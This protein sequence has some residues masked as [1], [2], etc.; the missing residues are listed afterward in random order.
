[1]P[2]G[3]VRMQGFTERTD[4]EA[5]LEKKPVVTITLKDVPAGAQVMLDGKAAMPPYEWTFYPS[6]QP[7]S[8]RIEADG[9]EDCEGVFIPDKTRS[10][11]CKMKKLPAEKREFACKVQRV[12][13][14]DVPLAV[15]ST[16]RLEELYG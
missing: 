3:D 4:L 8:Y 16:Q 11:R 6:K 2:T 10:V 15:L 12:M 1:M 5:A 7:H 13:Q 9:Y 14:M